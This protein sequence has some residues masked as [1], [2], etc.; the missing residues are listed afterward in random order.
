M[1]VA[2]ALARRK[3]ECDET[4][5]KLQVFRVGV[6]GSLVASGRL[7]DTHDAWLQ[8]RIAGLRRDKEFI[9][10]T[11]RSSPCTG[12]VVLVSCKDA[13]G[14]KR[15]HLRLQHKGLSRIFSRVLGAYAS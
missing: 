12:Q 3:T 8:A 13:L 2:D 15:T 5:Q 1:L 4:S 7:T 6:Y 10:E 11:Y 9:N 14:S